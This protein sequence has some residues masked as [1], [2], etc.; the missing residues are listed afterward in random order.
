M[1]RDKQPKA[2]SQ[3]EPKQAPTQATKPVVTAQKESLSPEEQK[4]AEQVKEK[5]EIIAPW[6]SEA[7]K[8]L[9]G[10]W[11][12]KAWIKETFNKD[13]TT[14]KDLKTLTPE[15]QKDFLFALK[16]Q[17]DIYRQSTGWQSPELNK[18]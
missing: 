14:L 13:I 2:F 15:E 18:G 4:L 10:F 17:L 1:A 5:L 3:K 8:E 9:K 11:D 7:I 6:V 12:S 16:F